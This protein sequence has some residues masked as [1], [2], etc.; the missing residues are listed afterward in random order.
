MDNEAQNEPG[1]HRLMWATLYAEQP[2]V[3]DRGALSAALEEFCGAVQLVGDAQTLL[4]AFPD[5][6]VYLGDG[7][8]IPAQALVLSGQDEQKVDQL[9]EDLIGQTWDFPE[10][11]AALA[12]CR[13]RVDVNEMLTTGLERFERLE[14]F[15]GVV[16]AALRVIPC[17]AFGWPSG[18][19]I[20]STEAFL[21]A[22][23]PG[24]GPLLF[25][26]INVRMFNVQ[27]RAQGEMLMD[28]MGMPVFGLPDVQCHYIGLEPQRV[29]GLLYNAAT[30]LF[31]EGDVIQD[32]HTIE[33][34]E[35]GQKWRCQHE[36]SL[37]KP[38]REVL[39][40]NPGPPYAAGDRA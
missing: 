17:R 40:I 23:Q 9:P 2:P 38:E 16:Q 27:G 3:V 37:S 29:A 31:E 12:A 4:Y 15:Y 6:M 8:S 18:Q 7:K 33:G 39:D 10:A 22:R 24:G 14:L 26:A 13:Y 5:H 35:P 1:P 25:P 30:Y 28:T 32:G 34:I 36:V 21:K 11:R 19:R 20:V